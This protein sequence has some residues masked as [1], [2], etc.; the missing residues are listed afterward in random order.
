MPQPPWLSY[1]ARL[2]VAFAQVREDPLLDEVLVKHTRDRARICMVASGGCTAAAL[3]AQPQ[4]ALLHCI[5][6]NPAQLA[7]ARIKLSLL[8]VAATS[9]R[10]LALGH[11]EGTRATR[12]A[13]I[14]HALE[15]AGISI[16]TLGQRDW[17]DEV[18]LDH[19]GRYEQLFRA[20]RAELLPVAGEIVS[21]LNLSDPSKQCGLIHPNGTLWRTLES[22]FDR[23]MALSN[24][25]ALFGEDATQNP[26]F[27]F[28]QHFLQRLRWAI[29][30]LPARSNPFLAQLLTGRF[31]PEAPHRWIGLP[32]PTHMPAVQW[33]NTLMVPAL[34]RN[35][36]TF[37][38]IHLSN[39]LD[40][41]TETEAKETLDTARAALRPGGIVIV[42]QLNSTL[43]I[44]ALGE[45]FHWN[46][47]LSAA[48]L[49]RD[50]SFFYREIFVGR[51]S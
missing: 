36:R 41:L 3:A 47:E 16:D 25:V 18:G 44:P 23:T 15:H 38:L 4:V 51:I 26:R 27:P 42:R 7:L 20:L 40:W 2:P 34:R 32:S 10:L 14:S 8:C 11:N 31:M 22:A 29:E 17:I 50:R 12:S 13:A 33:D 46:R 48:L 30:T 9:K 6:P 35:P 28:A 1:A 5:D 21:L 24:L 43:D 39:I 49:K 19:V 37:D 45:G